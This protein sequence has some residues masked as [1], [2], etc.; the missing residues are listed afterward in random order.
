MKYFY[1]AI[2]DDYPYYEVSEI[3]YKNEIDYLNHIL[4]EAFV[5]YDKTERYADID[6][7]LECNSY[8]I[9]HYIALDENNKELDDLETREV[10]FNSLSDIVFVEE[11]DIDDEEIEEE[12]DVEDEF[13]EDEENSQEDYTITR[14]DDNEEW[15]YSLP[16]KERIKMF[17]EACSEVAEFNIFSY[18]PMLNQI[19]FISEE[20]G[21]Y[22]NG[23]IFY[24]KDKFKRILDEIE[25]MEE[26]GMD[27][28]RF[29]NREI[30]REMDRTL[31]YLIL[32][33]GIYAIKF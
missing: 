10:T 26:E 23:G 7:F 12:Y 27:C 33:E 28:S 24:F 19:K 2:I 20:I 14:S 15:F 4:P 11:G 30:D 5:D 17:Y 18:F 13:V 16:Y 29:S 3:R 1:C 22:K 21:N 31:L 6:D 32:N 8:Y 9:T 25:E